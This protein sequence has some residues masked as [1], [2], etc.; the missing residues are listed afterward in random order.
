MRL[1]RLVLCGFGPFAERTEIDFRRLGSSSLLLIHGPTG[2]GKTSILDAIC[3]ALY[4]EV[5]GGE[6]RGDELRSHWARPELDTEVVLDFRLG[7][8]RFRVARS[9]KYRR[10]RL[11]GPGFT[12]EPARATLWCRTGVDARIEADGDDGQPLAAKPSDVERAI[13]ER[14][15]FTADE[16]RQVIVLPQGEF[17]RLITSTSEAREGVLEVLFRTDHYRG[18]ESAI[19]RAASAAR[20][21]VHELETRRETILGEA[22]AESA[23]EL[24]AA[25]GAAAEERAAAR[26]ELAGA[27]AEEERTRARLE[28]ARRIAERLAEQAAARDSLAALEA[29]AEKAELEQRELDAAKRAAG[30]ADLALRLK[31]SES[32]GEVRREAHERAV[33]LATEAHGA[34]ATT[35]AALEVER[36]RSAERDDLRR[37]IDR[38]EQMSERVSLWD[39]A[40]RAADV[41]KERAIGAQEQ[42]ALASRAFE[43]R[44]EEV[45]R[46]QATQASA[47]AAIE[48]LSTMRVVVGELEAARDR[49]AEVV[50]SQRELDGKDAE[51]REAKLALDAATVAR[52]RARE[53]SLRAEAAW[54]SGQAQVLARG[55]VRGA[56]CP[57]CGSTE[58]PR[59]ARAQGPATGDADLEATRDELAAADAMREQALR[60]S[61]RVSTEVAALAGRVAE[62][63]EETGGIERGQLEALEERLLAA[64]TELAESEQ[65]SESLED[66]AALVESAAAALEEAR[67]T[68]DRSA[69]ALAATRADETTCARIAEERARGLPEELRAPGALATVLG[70]RRASLLASEQALAEAE[71]RASEDRTRASDADRALAATH[72][73]AGAHREEHA[74]IAS[75]LDTRM[76]GAGF[77]ERAAFESAHR[78]PERV[79]ELEAALLDRDRALAAA[80]DRADR[81]D[82]EAG[83]MAAPD[84]EL[85]ERAH[86]SARE[87]ATTLGEASVRLDARIEQLDKSLESLATVE[88][89]L[90]GA[91][92]R[93][94]RL[95]RLSEIADGRKNP[96]KMSFQRFVLAALL[97]EALAAASARLRATSRGRYLLQRA[98]AP[99][100]RRIAGGLDLEVFDQY[101]GVARPVRTLSGGESFL[102]SLALALGLAD[103]VQ[104]HAGGIRLETLFVDE[105]FGS[106]DSESLD[107]AMRALEDL[108]RGGRLVGIISHV[109]ELKERIDVRLEVLPA[110]RGSTARLIVP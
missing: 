16:F 79:A 97:D 66:L 68:R 110:Q 102:A 8:E 39:E 106:L 88:A 64:S 41:A 77:A 84:L 62:L 67:E 72:S 83:S 82:R 65:A 103:V 60:D 89:E 47:A 52:D 59:P 29:G 36:A 5:S 17:R 37:A 107:L 69:T 100:D 19:T 14:L 95:G 54:Q 87:R 1:E 28:E 26:A 57:V 90:T 61:V 42:S 74:R 93:F 96:L 30:L 81:A 48:R 76:R 104:A 31:R 71:R 50:H 98:Q 55:L 6:R 40:R 78:T 33:A 94:G 20:G 80:R 18:I 58:H 9:P 101:T 63:I 7:A 2:A 32:E 56:P 11:R 21:A 109:A 3:F 99:G 22:R 15:G 86:Q 105:G 27:T 34:L 49:A 12:E 51:A 10:P 53:L 85:L 44:A 13:G 23:D 24:R 4:G 92:L 35:L 73:T 108:E 25:R 91:T 75:D 45:A 46:S 38:L 70:E 43:E